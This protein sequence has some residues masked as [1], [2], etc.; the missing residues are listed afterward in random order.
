M[1]KTFKLKIITPDKLFFEGDAEMVIVRTLSGE[2]GFMANHSWATKLLDVGKT[3][4][5]EPGGKKMR[6]AATSEGFIDVRDAVTIFI[7]SAEWPEEIDVKRSEERK[8][9]AQ[10]FL[11]ENKKPGGD[12][13]A[14]RK[15]E[16]SLKKA[17]TRLQVSGSPSRRGN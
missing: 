14:L 8:A 4:I 17:L 1:G 16:L 2:E 7:D 12:D 10:E 11:K 15:A 13:E 3:W 6:L 5:Q 9:A